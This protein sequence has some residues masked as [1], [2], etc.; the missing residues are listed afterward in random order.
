[1]AC[2]CMGKELYGSLCFGG[3]CHCQQTSLCQ[4]SVLTQH[5]V[6]RRMV[7]SEHELWHVP[8]IYPLMLD[9]CLSAK[10]SSP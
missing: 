10:F 9:V 2:L 8:C 7:V 6:W 1:M 5:L 4:T 3:A